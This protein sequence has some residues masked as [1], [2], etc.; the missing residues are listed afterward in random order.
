VA[1]ALVLVVGGAV[2]FA[3]QSLNHS[4]AGTTK[5]APPA[6]PPLT[7]L[8]PAAAVTR[9]GSVDLTAV[10]PANLRSDQSYQVRVFVNDQPTGRIDLPTND[11]D[12]TG[13]YGEQFTVADV[14][15]AEGVNSIRVTL[16]GVGGESVP[17]SPVS[18]TRDDVAPVITI[19][20]PT[21]RVYTDTDTLVGTTEPGA[22]IEITDAS[23]RAIDSSIS[24]GGRFSAD[25][26]LR[27]GNN[28]LT[29]KSTDAAGNHAIS[30]VTIVRAAS[31]ATIELTVAPTDIYA[32]QLPTT[33]DLTAVVRD[34]VGRPVADGTQVVFGISPPDSETTTYTA[35]TANGR[36][37]FTGPSIDPGDAVGSWLVTALVTLPSGIELRDDASFSLLAGAPKSPGQH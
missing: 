35:T 7:L 1:A 29:I 25:L 23:G 8:P 21:E 22:D 36:A 14:P 33:M 3:S 28:D 37:H 20:A 4:D 19:I 9:A 13:P 27:V 17:S 12:G 34:E 31:A 16:V 10:A 18:V 26:T 30:H 32:A 5:V 6:P 2:A 24:V 11:G 15:L